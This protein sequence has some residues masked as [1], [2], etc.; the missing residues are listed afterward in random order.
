[1]CIC[2]YLCVCIH[3]YIS[4]V[5]VSIIKIPS[6]RTLMLQR[7]A[8]SQLCVHMVSVSIMCVHACMDV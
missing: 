5:A 7:D 2:V 4:I 6:K 8:A 1:M 3:A